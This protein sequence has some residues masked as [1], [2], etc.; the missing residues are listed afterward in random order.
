M[1]K[2][3]VSL[4]RLSAGLALTILAACAPLQVAQPPSQQT[5]CLQKFRSLDRQL[6]ERGLHDAGAYRIPG[7]PYLRA[8]RFLASFARELDSWHKQE[9]WLRALRA[10]DQQA[11]RHELRNLGVQDPDGQARQLQDCGQQLVAA[12]L[13]APERLAALQ[14]QAEVPDDYSLG[15]RILGLYPLAVPFLRLGIANYHD[16]VRDMYAGPLESAAMLYGPAGSRPG[17]AWP[18]R[19]QSDGLGRPRLSNQQQQQLLR[20]HAPAWWVEQASVDDR[21]GQPVWR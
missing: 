11:R 18:T 14:R 2:C 15:A 4:K 21:P 16:H 3:A 1:I 7:Y 20:R 6:A 13:D 5:A 12:L 19:L 17:A 10:E 9:A 8:T